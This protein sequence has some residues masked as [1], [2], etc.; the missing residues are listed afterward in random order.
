MNTVA[1]QHL[2]LFLQ[3]VFPPD[4]IAASIYN[5]HSVG[6]SVRPVCTRCCFRMTNMIQACSKFRWARIFISNTRP[7]EILGPHRPKIRYLYR[8]T[9]PCPYGVACHRGY[10]LSN[11]CRRSHGLSHPEFLKPWIIKFLSSTR[12]YPYEQIHKWIIGSMPR[13]HAKKSLGH[14]KVPWAH[15][16]VTKQMKI[17]THLDHI[18]HSKTAS[19][20]NL[21]NR[22]TYRAFITNIR[23]D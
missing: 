23:Q 8:R 16:Y 22:W 9:P 17:I 14:V 6:P 20:T 15:C 1:V 3:V 12:V 13:K 5:I 2:H 18:S 7:D 4:S 11:S 19:G 10:W 21:S